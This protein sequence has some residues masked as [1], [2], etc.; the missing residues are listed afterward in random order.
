MCILVNKSGF[1]KF[2]NIVFL[3]VTPSLQAIAL[4]HFDGVVAAVHDGYAAICFHPQTI[5]EETLGLLLMLLENE[6]SVS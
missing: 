1:I 5:V 4:S 2:V 3:I 6:P